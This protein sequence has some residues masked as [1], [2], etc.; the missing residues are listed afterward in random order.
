MQTPVR[1]LPAL[2]T[3]ALC[4]QLSYAQ[5]PPNG[6]FT[7]NSTSA[8][9]R[10]GASAADSERPADQPTPRT[11]RDSQIAHQQLL[12]KAKQGG[13]DVYQSDTPTLKDA[14]KDHFYVGV[15]IN[16]SLATSTAFR[17]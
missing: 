14:Y 13:I 11:D 12:E 2:F 4:T 6:A 9:S 8:S 3:A 16:R 7:I 5:T 17:R 10:D 1:F 15:A